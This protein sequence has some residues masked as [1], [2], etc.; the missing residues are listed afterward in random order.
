MQDFCLA[1]TDIPQGL[2]HFSIGLIGPI[3]ERWKQLITVMEH[4]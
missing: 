3:E 1:S 4:Y 2:V